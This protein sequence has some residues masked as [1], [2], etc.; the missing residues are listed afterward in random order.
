MLGGTL[1]FSE[2]R[3]GF[4]AVHGLRVIDLEQECLVALN[5]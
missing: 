2:W 1:K 5:D 3:D 4:A